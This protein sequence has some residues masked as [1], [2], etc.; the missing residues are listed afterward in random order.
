MHKNI[1]IIFK[2]MKLIYLCKGKLLIIEIVKMFHFIHICYTLKKAWDWIY[3]WSTKNKI[4]NKICLPAF[5]SWVEL[6]TTL[7]NI[8]QTIQRATW[9]YRFIP[10]V[11]IQTRGWFLE[12]ISFT[13]ELFFASNWNEGAYLKFWQNQTTSPFPALTNAS[14]Q[15]FLS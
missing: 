1:L 4:E 3:Y 11:R 9:V 12:W 5:C 15:A 6:S 14:R 2:D 10:F 7:N 13:D 8:M